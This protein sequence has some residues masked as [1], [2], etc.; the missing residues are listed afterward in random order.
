MKL[1]KEQI[2]ATGIAK[3]YYESVGDDILITDQVYEAIGIDRF[4]EIYRDW[5]IPTREDLNGL[6]FQLFEDGS[7]EIESEPNKVLER[8]FLVN[9]FIDKSY[10]NSPP[11]ANE[12]I[13]GYDAWKE[14]NLG[15]DD[16]V[17]Y[18]SSYQWPWIKALQE[19]IQGNDF[20]KDDLRGN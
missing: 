17:D 16:D 7:I 18:Y 3:S 6:K 20:T 14:F 8:L 2:E 11:E 15:G 9:N 10:D 1:T 12:V 19:L 5:E 13:N 4:H